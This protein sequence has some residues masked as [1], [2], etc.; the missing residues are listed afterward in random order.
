ME[1]QA[2]INL[3][4]LNRDSVLRALSRH[5]GHENGIGISQVVREATGHN[6]DK[7][8]ERRA[9]DIISALR[10][11]GTAICASPST[12]YYIAATEEELEACCAWLR[13]RAM[14]S[15][16]LES[17][18]RRIAMPDLLNQLRFTEQ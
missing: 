13:S 5:Q 3:D 18:M 17:K 12:G 1:Q 15:L 6:S 4:T 2:L 10:E 9:R 14:H 16:R 7:A 11:E 8:S